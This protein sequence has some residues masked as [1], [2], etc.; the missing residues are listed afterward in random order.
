MKRIYFDVVVDKW[1]MPAAGKP[2]EFIAVATERQQGEIDRLVCVTVPL[3]AKM[4]EHAKGKTFIEDDIRRGAFSLI[5]PK[6]KSWE[7]VQNLQRVEIFVMSWKY[8]VAR[9]AVRAAA[10][11]EAFEKGYD[12]NL[13]DLGKMGGR[14][15]AAFEA[16]PESARP[17]A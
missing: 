2:E 15:L 13:E 3:H 12:P 16:S 11:H 10:I 17:E 9:E 7:D 6:P 1:S 5:N 4:W 14:I 8:G